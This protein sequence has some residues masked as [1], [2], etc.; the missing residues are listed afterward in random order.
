[1][2]V[3]ESTNPANTNYTALRAGEGESRSYR[4]VL[5]LESFTDMSSNV[6]QDIEENGRSRFDKRK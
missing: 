5:I 1:M 6:T 2:N 3:P 4:A